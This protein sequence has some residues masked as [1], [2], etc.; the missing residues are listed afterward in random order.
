M[1]GFL[2]FALFYG[3]TTTYAQMQVECHTVC[4]MLPHYSKLSEL[5]VFINALPYTEQ[6]GNLK[7]T[8]IDTLTL[9]GNTNLDVIYGTITER[10]RKEGLLTKIDAAIV[11][12][13]EGQNYLIEW[14][15]YEN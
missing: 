1:K 6:S 9:P 3:F 7:Y 14:I 10:Y 2:I 13:F 4:T 5:P 15:R 12:R 8:L 11:M